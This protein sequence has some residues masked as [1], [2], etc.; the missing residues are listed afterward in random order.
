MKKI[1]INTSHNIVIDFALASTGSRIGAAMID[2]MILGA[3]AGIVATVFHSIPTVMLLL[4]L[5]VSI[6]Y[7]LLFEVLNEGQSPGKQIASIRVTSIKGTSPSLKAYLMRWVF[8]LLD[9]TGSLSIVGLF[10]ISS[11]RYKQRVGD[12]IA[13]TAVV[14]TKQGA[15]VGLDSL[16][17]LSDIDREIEYPNV[18]R[19]SDKDML[20]VKDTIN[21]AR[22]T[23]NLE[24]RKV[25][26]ELAN[27][28]ANDLGAKLEGKSHGKFLVQ[29]LEEYIILTR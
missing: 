20:L 28:I 11:T 9:I 22:K 17:K 19:Y 23:R 7:H 27:K 13:Q 25:L 2:T 18:I 6:F 3:Y 15:V 10:F 8:R 14:D 29:I 16:L 12:I 26:V 5:P 4:I 1:G 24:T 21:R